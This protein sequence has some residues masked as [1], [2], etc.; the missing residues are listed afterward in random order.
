M[1]RYHRV[2][3]QPW[4]GPQY[5]GEGLWKRKVLIVGEAHYDEWS[6]GEP[7]RVSKH[8]LHPGF[9]QQCIQE[10]VDGRREARYWNRVRNRLGGEE[11]ENQHSAVFWNKVAFYNFIQSP[12][13]GGPGATPKPSQ[14]A[15]TATPFGEV[16]GRLKP[17]RV[18]FAGTRLWSYVPRRRGKVPDVEVAGKSLPVEFF[19]IDNGRHVYVTATPNPRSQHFVRTLTPALQ[20][21]VLRDW[22]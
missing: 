9:T 6:D 12:L 1:A 15:E 3:F 22:A 2:F 16:L 14:W 21:F 11:H 19:E 5:D 4:V 20:E 7:A 13:A 8:D 18:V 10:L 17:A